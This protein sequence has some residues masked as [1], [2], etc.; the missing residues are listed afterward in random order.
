MFLSNKL[1]FYRLGQEDDAKLPEN[2]AGCSSCSSDCQ[3]STH[4][5][6]LSLG[7]SSSVSSIASDTVSIAIGYMYLC[8]L[9]LSL[10]LFIST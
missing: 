1:F 5:S 2:E 3:S 7:S 9:F 4:S 6:C 10:S 8:A